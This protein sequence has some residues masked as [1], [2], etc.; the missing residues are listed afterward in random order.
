LFHPGAEN[1]LHLSGV[2]KTAFH[3]VNFADSLLV[4]E[5][6]IDQHQTQARGA[7]RGAGDIFLASQQRKQRAGNLFKIHSTL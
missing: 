6:V 5:R 4:G 2:A 3:A 7:V 1:N